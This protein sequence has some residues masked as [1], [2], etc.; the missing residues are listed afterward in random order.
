MNKKIK[1][2]WIMVLVI[3]TFYCDVKKHG[4]NNDKNST[5]IALECASKARLKIGN[6]A[7][8]VK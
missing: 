4:C 7:Q 1:R 5:Q 8:G 2:K 3:I 6:A